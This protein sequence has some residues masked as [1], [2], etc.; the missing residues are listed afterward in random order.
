MLFKDTA[1]FRQ[2]GKE[3]LENV[4]V[5]IEKLPQSKS[6][7]FFVR[8]ANKSIIFTATILQKTTEVR[9]LNNS[10]RNL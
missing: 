9:I 5:S 2:T 3:T 8:L 4:T 7:Y 10:S 1:K 6:V